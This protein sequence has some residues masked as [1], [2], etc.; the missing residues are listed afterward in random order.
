MVNSDIHRHDS[1][2]VH[3][4]PHILNPLP[5]PFPPYPSGLFQS[6]G[7]GCPASCIEL[8]LAIYLPNGN[9][10]VS[11]LFS[12]LIP[13]SPS[14]TNVHKIYVHKMYTKK[15][16]TKVCSLHL[17]FLCCPACGIIGTIFINYIYIYALIYSICL[18]LSDLLHSV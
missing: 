7:L 18:P 13:S 17:C 6:T 12:Q 5:P 15:M 8:A 3:I 1:A 10:H 4:C 2:T 11:M 16:N 9:V 14:P